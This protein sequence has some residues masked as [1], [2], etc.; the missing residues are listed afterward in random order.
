M[1]QQINQTLRNKSAD[2]LQQNKQTQSLNKVF[3]Y[4]IIDVRFFFILSVFAHHNVQWKVLRSSIELWI[5]A[6]SEN[7]DRPTNEQT[8]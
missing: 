1:W 3:V 4:N 5:P 8:G 6:A 7:Y 2:I